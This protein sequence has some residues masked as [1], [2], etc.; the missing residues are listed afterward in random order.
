M[1]GQKRLGEDPGKRDQQFLAA[2]AR[3]NVRGV[4][5]AL[6]DRRDDRQS[7]VADTMAMGVIEALEVEIEHRQAQPAAGRQALDGIGQETAVVLPVGPFVDCR[8]LAPVPDGGG[9]VSVAV[10]PRAMGVARCMRQSQARL[11][12][13]AAL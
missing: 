3:G 5:V 2:P 9:Q 7:A 11:H 4:G 12:A 8:C 10:S 13:G 1:Q 6:Q